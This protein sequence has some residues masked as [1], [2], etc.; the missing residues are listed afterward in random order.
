MKKALLIISLLISSI[1]ISNA[2]HVIKLQDHLKN[3]TIK[4]D[5][6]EIEYSQRY[7]QPLVIKY[8][9]QC[10]TGDEERAGMSFKKYPGVVTSDDADYVDNVWDKGHMAPAG[11]FTCNATKLLETFSYINC[12][13][14]HQGLNRGPWKELERFEKDL[15]KVYAFVTIEIRVHFEDNPKYWLKTGALVPVGFSKTIICDG[16]WFEFYFPNKDVAGHD[17]SEFKTN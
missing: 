7:Q 4:N 2:Q 11:A 6:F 13:L 10:P 1:T 15:T 17:W 8:T 5:I 9:V 14:Q 3:V 12:A 16:E